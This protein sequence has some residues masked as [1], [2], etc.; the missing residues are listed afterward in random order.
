MTDH[1]HEL[2]RKVYHRC[3]SIMKFTLDLKQQENPREGRNN[4]QFKFFKKLLMEKTYQNL[5]GLFEELEGDGIIQATDYEEDVKNGYKDT[6]SGGSGYLNT[7]RLND[8]IS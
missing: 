5:R 8:L 6:P 4:P 3:M 7:D 2:A 1:D